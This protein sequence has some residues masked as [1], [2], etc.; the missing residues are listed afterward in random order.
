[1]KI[2]RLYLR[3]YRT[4]ADEVSLELPGGLIGIY[5]VNGAGKSALIESIRWTLYGKARTS[6][7]EIRTTGV[8]TECITEVEFEH[9]G[10]LY[11]AR[12]TISGA[13]HTVK[14][15]VHADRQLIAATVSD[16]AKYIHS[17]IGMDDHAFRSSVF[18]EQK[19]IAAFSNNQPAKRKELVLRLL[20]ITPL[21]KAKE[22]AAKDARQKKDQYDAVKALLQDLDQLHAA[23]DDAAARA[24][25]AETRL[26]E[27]TAALATAKAA[28]GE[29]DER[30]AQLRDLETQVREIEADGRRAREQLDAATELVAQRE[31]ELA[32]LA[33]A[34]DQLATLEPEAAGLHGAEA[35]LE[36]LKELD[37]AERALAAIA[38]PT[39]PPPADEKA[40]RAADDAAR[41]LSDELAE[42]KG[43]TVAAEA[44]LARAREHASHSAQLSGEADCPMCGQ[45]LGAAFAT[46][47]QQRA[48][49]LA[50]AEARLTALQQRQVELAPRAAEARQQ[51]TAAQAALEAARQA[52]AAYEQQQARRVEAEQRRDAILAGI[53]PAPSEGELAHLAAEVERRRKATIDA[54]QLRGR[55]ERLP[56]VE[57]ELAEARQRAQ[58]A[59]DKRQN[60][61]EK[62]K[63]LGF[64]PAALDAAAAAADRARAHRDALAEAES[65]AR[66]EATRLRASATAATEALARAAEQHDQVRGLETETRHLER[67][68]KLMSAFRDNVVGTVGPTLA[69]QAAELFAELTDHEYDQLDVNPETYELQITDGGQS[70]GMDRF[71]GSEVDLANLALRVAISEHVRFQSG[72]AVGLLVLDEVFGPL[73]SDR[74]DR[75]LMALERLKGRFRQVLVV[76]HDQE[77]KEQ[78]PS[79]IEVVKLA[80]RR[81]TAQLINA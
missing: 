77:I 35:R 41:E 44:D 5:G 76:T 52:H 6:I 80:P 62:R 27:A 50:E 14:A 64:D 30:L 39:P 29:A 71:S 3:N 46:V 67:L 69:A 31:R 43:R 12:R 81:A 60:L 32:E 2:T 4:F 34:S 1:M 72:G 42:L 16:V 33:T 54:H 70:F 28:A 9:E 51:A 47:Q 37:R 21:D 36:A 61:L 22:A 26:A 24:E 74:K 23:A 56:A 58:E 18:A 7:P 17:V 13:N 65:G 63:A 40:V 45:A 57:A 38:V 53:D 15:E 25:E 48:H 19:Q 10:H 59:Q 20:G 8:Q 68:S 79:A 49:D 11:L 55:L 78:L 73:D 66:V 75:M